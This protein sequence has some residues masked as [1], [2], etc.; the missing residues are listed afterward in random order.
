MNG[1]DSF[2]NPR[3]TPS[4]QGYQ[5]ATLE[6]QNQ[7]SR[8]QIIYMNDYMFRQYLEFYPNLQG[9]SCEKSVLYLKENNEIIASESLTFDLRTLPG[10]A[11]NVDAKTFME[12][13]KINK[14]CKNLEDFVE[15][16]NQNAF[17]NISM[18][19]TENL[20]NK[21]TDYMNL[22]FS[23]ID[24]SNIL[25]ENNQILIGTIK[26]LIGTLPKET[27]I[28]QIVNKKLDEYRKETE[29]SEKSRGETSRV[30]ELTK[31]N[32]PVIIP[33]GNEEEQKS[34]SSRAA[35]VNIAII[36]YGALNIGII[37]AIALLK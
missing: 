5:G 9:L 7:S 33:E 3:Q 32:L 17:N 27:L 35:F 18:P 30:L 19:N 31:P 37:L 15:L 10:E 1:N 28:G 25:I 24:S 26:D 16:L 29:K 36:I 22:Y 14:S 8:T 11:W 4:Y 23:V 13:I 2:T 12:I 21:I 6:N 34:Y 20:E